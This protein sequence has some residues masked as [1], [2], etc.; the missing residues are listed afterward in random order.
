MSKIM[1]LVY[2]VPVR[3]RATV[4]FSI[5]KRSQGHRVQCTHCCTTAGQYI[6][7]IIACRRHLR[8][9]KRQE[10]SCRPCRLYLLTVTQRLNAGE[11]RTGFGGLL[12]QSVPSPDDDEE[13]QIEH[14][15]DDT[16]VYTHTCR[17]A[18]FAFATY[19]SSRTRWKVL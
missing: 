18:C 8:A 14:L 16:S 1:T 17:S 13:L 4:T 19:S 10:R 7:S 9:H 11:H 2:I 12:I 6:V 3:S 15:I 5:A